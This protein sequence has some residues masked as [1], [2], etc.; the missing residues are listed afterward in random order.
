MAYLLRVR[1]QN[2]AAIFCR[3]SKF[4]GGTENL[5]CALAGLGK[6]GVAMDGGPVKDVGMD[7]RG[8]PALPRETVSLCKYSGLRRA[9]LGTFL[10]SVPAMRGT[11]IG[12]RVGGNSE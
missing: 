9:F 3:L 4:R 6:R 11:L 5:G 1:Q 10:D 7:T 2:F 12:D 8:E